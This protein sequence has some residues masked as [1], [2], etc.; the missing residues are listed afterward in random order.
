M[1]FS[2]QEATT[3]FFTDSLTDILEDAN[4]AVK[5]LGL[6]ASQVRELIP[7]L[8]FRAEQLERETRL[9][10]VRECRLTEFE[11][12]VIEALENAGK[13]GV[14]ALTTR[15]LLEAAGYSFSGPSKTLLASMVDRGLLCQK[16][17]QGYALIS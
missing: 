16:A 13:K 12:C 10:G 4:A 17:G 7:L 8:S 5:L 9:A 2:R 3:Q 11:E 6:K 1:A 14:S 15:P